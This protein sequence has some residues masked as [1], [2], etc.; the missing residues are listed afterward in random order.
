MLGKHILKH[1]LYQAPGCTQALP[2]L[3][4]LL[5]YLLPVVPCVLDQ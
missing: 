2:G 3:V 1:E 5:L 4:I